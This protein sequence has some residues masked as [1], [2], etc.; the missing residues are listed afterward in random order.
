MNIRVLSIPICA[1]IAG[2][3][4]AGI[5]PS[6]A[7]AADG[8]NLVSAAR[9]A[10]DKYHDVSAALADGYSSTLSCVSGEGGAMGIHFAKGGLI[11]DG[12]VDVQHPELL[13]YAPGAS[14]GLNL[15]AVEYLTLAPV[16]DPAHPGTPPV[17]M[18]QLF[19]YHG[20]PNRYALP[21]FYA[22]HVWAWKTNPRGM[23]SDWNPTVSCVPYSG[24]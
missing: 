18:G 22:L 10:T 6:A 15:V 21:A 11:G 17:L 13:V 24:S 12:I 8:D 4:L 19:D 7:Y 5:L 20:S 9:Q 1:L 2:L 14:G 3:G 23:F 16:W